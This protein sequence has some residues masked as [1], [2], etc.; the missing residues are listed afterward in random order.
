L[1]IKGDQNRAGSVTRRVRPSFADDVYDKEHHQSSAEDGGDSGSL[2]AATGDGRD[3]RGVASAKAPPPH[4]GTPPMSQQFGAVPADIIIECGGTCG[5]NGTEMCESALAQRRSAQLPKLKDIASGTR[6]GGGGA[7]GVGGETQGGGG[8]A[9]MRAESSEFSEEFRNF[10][11]QSRFEMTDLEFVYTDCDTHAAE[12]AELYTYSE[13]D[14]WALNVQAYRN[15]ADS[16][17]VGLFFIII[18]YYYLIY[19]LYIVIIYYSYIYYY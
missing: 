13:I 19:L 17:R 12:L 7:S 10:V 2:A 5:A 1:C 14:D 11:L 4:F 6:A 16:K 8:G 15:Y 9:R 3:N 18:Y